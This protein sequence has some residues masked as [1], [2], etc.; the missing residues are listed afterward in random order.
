MSKI[1]TL[2]RVHCRPLRGPDDQTP[3]TLEEAR[4]MIEAESRRM[5]EEAIQQ[6]LAS[7]ERLVQ[8]PTEH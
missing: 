6:V 4:A 8:R 1:V 2:A 3:I 7:L 5:I